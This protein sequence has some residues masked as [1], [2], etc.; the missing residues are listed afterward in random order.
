MNTFEILKL[1]FFACKKNVLMSRDS[2][3]FDDNRFH[4]NI[5]LTTI[6]NDQD[7]HTIFIL[8]VIEFKPDLKHV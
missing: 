7:V 8:D 2:P 4:S 3:D 1:F 6:R 5:V